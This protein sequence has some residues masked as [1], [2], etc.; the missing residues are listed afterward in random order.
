MPLRPVVS[1]CGSP[2]SNISLLLER[3]LNQLLKFVP[4]HLP[5]TA[6]CLKE[7]HSL[8]K[9]PNSCIVASSDVVSLY[10]NIPVEESI[11]AAM[12][13]LCQHRE[14]VDMFY[15]ELSDVRQLLRF[16]LQSNY[17][18]FGDAV[19][20]Q[21]KGL[22]MGNHLAQPMAISSLCQSW[23]RRHWPYHL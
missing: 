6:E 8:G 11:E 18:A 13:L 20:R 4:A 5:D 16:V 3:I 23:R 1:T 15:L 10:S 14:E 17:F 19:Y 21:Q 12:E 9:V 22:A 2:P 7:L